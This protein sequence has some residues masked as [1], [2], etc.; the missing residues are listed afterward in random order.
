ML[1]RSRLGQLG[2]CLD[3]HDVDQFGLSDQWLGVDVGWSTDRPAKL[4]TFPI[5]T[6]S[7]SEG[8]FELVHQSVV[9]LPHWQVQGDATGRWALTMKLHIDTSLAESRMHN[10]N[11]IQTEESLVS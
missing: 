10:L 4:W 6:V 8:G 2:T 9:L 1:F 11:S 5:E 7:Q 3:L